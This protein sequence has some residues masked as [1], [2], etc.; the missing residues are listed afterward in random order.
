MPDYLEAW[1]KKNAWISHLKK[2][3][4]AVKE[5]KAPSTGAAAAARRTR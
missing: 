5:L 1:R 3:I 2:F 4:K